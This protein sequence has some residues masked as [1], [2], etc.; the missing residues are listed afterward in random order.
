MKHPDNHKP[1][2]PE[3]MI[4]LLDNS[5][6]NVNDLDDFEKDAVEG[7]SG[8]VSKDKVKPLI[9]EINLEISKKVT[10]SKN[11]TQKILWMSAAAS[12][13]FIVFVSVYFLNQNNT[14]LNLALN[15]KTSID[16]LTSIY[17]NNKNIDSTL[18]SDDTSKLS[19]KKA[20]LSVDNNKYTRNKESKQ[21]DNLK[22]KQSE[23]LNNTKR[24]QNFKQQLSNN[25]QG[26]L[27][28]SENEQTIDNLVLDEKKNEQQDIALN[29]AKP[30]IAKYEADEV[31]PKNNDYREKKTTATKSLDIQSSA[32]NS[33]GVS[34]T[35][36]LVVKDSNDSIIKRAYFKGGEKAIKEYVLNYFKNQ[37][38]AKPARGHYLV[39][40]S[41]DENGKFKVL[42]LT[43]ISR[44]YCGC[45]EEIKLAL[46]SMET[47][48][49]AVLKNKKIISE[50]EFDLIFN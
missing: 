35:E 48:N 24:P 29:A 17:Q 50:I 23:I 33:S 19:E 21:L 42:N 7:F 36:S 45:L 10:S 1:L 44:D 20:V 14:N 13:V 15:K 39:L 49:P 43:Q 22:I 9:E 38:I 34:L 37:L 46:N 18:F 6:S 2:S 11:K 47:W 27:A 26:V 8:Y 4:E 5:S 41:V 30:S 12:I 32:F 25:Y 40:G 31:N 28:S 16:N 3:E